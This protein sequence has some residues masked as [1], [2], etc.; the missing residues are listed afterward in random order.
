MTSKFDVW[1]LG[2]LLAELSIGADFFG[3]EEDLLNEIERSKDDHKMGF[4][5]RIRD[6]SIDP[7]LKV[8]L[9]SCLSYLPH[10]RPML[11][12]MLEYD[13]LKSVSRIQEMEPIWPIMVHSFINSMTAKD[14]LHLYLGQ[15]CDCDDK[16][17]P[18]VSAFNY[19]PLYVKISDDLHT[20]M[21]DCKKRIQLP[22]SQVEHALNTSGLQDIC[23][24]SNIEYDDM[25]KYTGQWDFD[26]INKSLNLF[27][28]RKGISLNWS[29]KEKNVSYQ[30]ERTI[31]FRNLIAKYPL[32]LDTLIS[33]C[34]ADIPRNMRAAIYGALLGANGDTSIIFD[35]LDCDLPMSID[36]QVVVYIYKMF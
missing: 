28:R 34:V 11:R 33:K 15:N 1:S 2:M 5:G 31:M 14:I 4:L 29:A 18:E 17:I 24:D 32:S 6:S 13:F 16:G 26:N 25:W 9:I 12:D 20:I 35:I 36:Q 27:K 21:E 30:R 23:I 3:T 7:D 8:F 10:D 22:I 19:L